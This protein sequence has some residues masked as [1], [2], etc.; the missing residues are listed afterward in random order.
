M[1]DSGKISHITSKTDCIESPKICDVP[2]SLTDNSEAHATAL[3]SRVVNLRGEN[4]ASTVSLSDTLVYRSICQILLSVPALVRE[5]IIVL[6]MPIKAVLIVMKN[7]YSILAY[8][9]QRKDGLFY[10]PDEHTVPFQSTTE[11]RCNIT[12]CM[13]IAKN[14]YGRQTTN[15]TNRREWNRTINSAKFHS[16]TEKSRQTTNKHDAENSGRKQLD[17]TVG[18]IVKANTPAE[19]LNLR[20][21]RL[22]T[23]DTTKPHLIEGVLPK[24]THTT[25]GCTVFMKSKLR[26]RYNGSFTK[27]KTFGHPHSDTKGKIQV[28][29]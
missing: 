19:F 10:I 23:L 13:A 7:K 29:P 5:H 1:I 4:G 24:S 16:S 9:T 26:K 6:F 20:L 11:E 21:G 22:V 14:L 8:G 27:A 15:C 2:I 17:L 28:A 3:E 18:N 25:V 12:A